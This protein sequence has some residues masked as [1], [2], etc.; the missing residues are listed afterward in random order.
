MLYENVQP[1]TARS[2]PVADVLI[3]DTST[4]VTDT[5]CSAYVC[6]IRQL[7]NR[8]C[9]KTRYA[10]KIKRLDPLWLRGSYGGSKTIDSIRME[11][12]LAEVEWPTSAVTISITWPSRPAVPD[13]GATGATGWTLN[14]HWLGLHT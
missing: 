10:L 11:N 8:G 7:L 3:S 4:L 9:I 2:V 1:D 5:R 12:V 6:T 14:R 13:T